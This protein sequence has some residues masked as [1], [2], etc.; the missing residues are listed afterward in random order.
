MVPV[1]VPPRPVKTRHDRERA[2][3]ADHAHHV[4]QDGLAVP[5]PERLL[6]GLRVAVVEGGREVEVVK[7]VV[8]PREDEFAG[9]DQAQAV[10]ELGADR[11]GA[12][13]AAVEAEQGGAGAPA[14]AGQGEHAGVLV[15]GVGGDVQDAGRGG[16][17]ADPVPG[18][19]RAAVGVQLLAG[20]GAGEGEDAVGGGR[21]PG[22]RWDLRGWP[23]VGRA[24]R[25][26][27]GDGR[28]EDPCRH[29]PLPTA[30][31]SVPPAG[32]P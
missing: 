6:D 14:A 19:R 11:V 28:Q 10:E 25:R 20:D 5:A 16:E 13:F 9:A 15:V 22:R 31:P 29:P 7:A 8:A 26:Q 4:L 23:G 32:R 12:R 3:E 30:P 2:I 1:A 27:C 17:L 21:G 24:R 18:A